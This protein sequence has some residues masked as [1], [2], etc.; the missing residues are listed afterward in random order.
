[1]GV[2]TPISTASP[3][4]AVIPHVVV[5][6][7]VGF[8]ADESGR[9]DGADQDW[10]AGPADAS[11]PQLTLAEQGFW[12]GLF[13]LLFVAVAAV[14]DVMNFKVV[15]ALVASTLSGTQVWL[16]V[17]AFTAAAVGPAHLAGSWLRR[18]PASSRISAG[19]ILA[20]VPLGLVWAGLGGVA[21]W[22]RLAQ[23][24]GGPVQ[25]Q[26][27]L[28]A[29]DGAAPLLQPATGPDAAGL[30][31]MALLFLLLF[32]AG[33]LM[34][35]WIAVDHGPDRIEM[36]GRHCRL[37]REA[38]RPAKQTTRQNRMARRRLMR[39]RLAWLVTSCWAVTAAMFGALRRSRQRGRR[40]RVTLQRDTAAATIG[41]LRRTIE[42]T[43]EDVER[44]AQRHVKQLDA[45]GAEAQELKHLARLILATRVGSPAGT[46]A[47][48]HR[49]PAPAGH[50]R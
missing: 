45:A 20:I 11:E 39:S 35:F 13:R 3:P 27:P 10:V 41:R 34:A 46:S 26:D 28:A 12:N 8:R 6:P 37:R 14:G 42:I 30:L 48:G 36:W 50:L 5:T 21:F 17:V 24:T 47:I 19:R 33:G 49:R 1:M 31:P 2:V 23:P 43:G 4:E 15:V 32:V 22:L 16:L 7:G 29:L 44:D 9:A 18:R 38:R 25:A 40:R